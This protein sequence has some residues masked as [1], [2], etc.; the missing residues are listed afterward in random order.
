M[1][2]H[3][4]DRCCGW[5]GELSDLEHHVQSCPMRDAPLMTELLESSFYVNNIILTETM[6][7]VSDIYYKEDWDV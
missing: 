3:H 2:C 6:L 4:E 1:F 5:H 7:M